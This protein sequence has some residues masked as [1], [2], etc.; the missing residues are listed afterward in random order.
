[1]IKELPWPLKLIKASQETTEPRATEVV[2]ERALRRGPVAGSG[3]KTKPIPEAWGLK[4]GSRFS[5]LNKAVHFW[6]F[7]HGG[8][9]F[10]VNLAHGA[11][12]WGQYG[13]VL[14]PGVSRVIL[15]G[16]GVS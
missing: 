4:P 6:M 11:R 3:V 16:Y 15:W 8:M 1:M 7:G 9:K 2:C 14:V 12:A 5:D 13:T 10:G